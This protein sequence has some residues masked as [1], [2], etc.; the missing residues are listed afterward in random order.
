[1]G[2][3]ASA[4]VMNGCLVTAKKLLMSVQNA[5]L[6]IGISRAVSP[7]AKNDFVIE[8]IFKHSLGKI[9]SNR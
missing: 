3:V 5:S 2:T 1:M 7:K 9:R 8:C 6:L 4:V